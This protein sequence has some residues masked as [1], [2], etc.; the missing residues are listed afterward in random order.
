M[1][2]GFQ[3]LAGSI[4]A[5]T[6]V[7][8]AAQ[9]STG[10]G[11]SRSNQGGSAPLAGPR[12][13]PSADGS[14]RPA[15]SGEPAVVSSP[16]VQQIGSSSSHSVAAPPPPKVELPSNL[17]T[18][19]QIEAMSPDQLDDLLGLKPKYDIP[20]AARR[21]LEQVGILGVDEGG[22][23]PGAMSGQDPGLVHALLA[24]NDGQLVSRWGHILLRRALVSRFDAPTGMD[25]AD[26]AALRAGLLL[27]MGEG[28]AARALVQDVDAGNFT[29]LMDATVLDTAIATG[30]MTAVCP[31]ITLQGDVLKD[32]RWQ[33]SKAICE[34]F[35]GDE[36]KSML[37]L[38]RAMNH[39]TM[40]KIDILLAQKYAG[41]AGKARQ[42]V[43]IEWN[44]VSAITPWRYALAI[45]T[46]LQPPDALM[47]GAGP[48][49]SYTAALA[50]MVPL[51][52]RAAAAD[53][54][55]GAGVL[56]S[57]AMVDLYSQIYD[58][59][60]ITGD[61]RDRS[62]GLRDAYRAD[63]AGQRLKAIKALWRSAGDPL[64]R[65]SRQVLTAYAA[66]RLPVEKGFAGDAGDLIASM[67]AA[68]LDQNAERWAQ[69]T[70]VGSAGWA[71]LMVAAPT[72]AAPVS[73]SALRSFHD[74]DKSTAASRSRFLLAG[75]AGLGRVDPGTIKS[76]S[77][78]VG[79]N[80]QRQT[81]W[82]RLIDG[83][84]KVNNPALVAM[85]AGLGMQ[86]DSW[87]KMTA[88]HL[89][90]IV[91]ALDKVGLGA[92]ARMI[93]AEAVARG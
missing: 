73:A 51:P 91:S 70:P 26:F 46:G 3:L 30:D 92:E 68:G 71:Q 35:T 43:T 14:P 67:L 87:D 28:D 42:A 61:W 1:K 89:F 84:A 7:W 33:V 85:L 19:R 53:V 34:A 44:K 76:F 8:A 5:L 24:G 54:A 29:P 21:S 88:L 75:L 66:A 58:D 83:A 86:G 80:L 22:F 56:S 36:S 77:D 37:D 18:L 38:D 62:E 65:Y 31:A 16:V 79:V 23:G 82:T 4:L 64:G 45:A 72:R 13:T 27:R 60:D 32:P 59:E 57:A 25:P 63:D 17:P 48:R 52:A 93:A 55:G 49:Y 10:P 12:S 50:P 11:T 6:S 90:H 39:G 78:A 2:R 15:A 74:D 41:A 47:N 40:S 69:F 81:R 20:P 9:T